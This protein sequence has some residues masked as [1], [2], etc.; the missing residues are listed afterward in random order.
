MNFG[1]EIWNK[2]TKVVVLLLGL[3]A[4]LAV[5]VWY[6]PIIRQ[7]EQM[8]RESLKL[9]EKIARETAATD[10]LKASIEAQRDPRTVERLA[11]ESLGYAKPGETVVRFQPGSTNPPKAQ[12]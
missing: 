3:A 7:N 1:L 5:I 10:K 2:L 12:P 11:R 4:I 8:Q 6:L 9:D